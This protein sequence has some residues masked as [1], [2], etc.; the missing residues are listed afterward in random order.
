MKKAIKN[1]PEL[2]KFIGVAI[3]AAITVIAIGV[4]IAQLSLQNQ[5]ETYATTKA[6]PRTIAEQEESVHLSGNHE[7][8]Q[9]G[10]ETI[11]SNDRLVSNTQL[12]SNEMYLGH[13]R[14]A[15]ADPSSL[16]IIGSYGKDE[17]Q[18]FE[19]LNS[20]AAQALMKLIYAARH[21]KIWIVPVSAFRSFERQKILFDNQ[22]ERRGSIKEAAKISA[23]SGY[24]EH[25]TGLAVD[26]TDGRFPKQDITR[27][28]EHTDAFFWLKKHANE[29]GFEMSFP[30]KN[31]QGV[32]YEPWHWRFVGSA[33]AA[34]IFE[35]AKSFESSYR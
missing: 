19:Y 13:F 28:F 18:R 15:E 1:F 10:S 32:I 17:Y 12:E 6:S 29:F 8:S 26:L 2:L 16:T 30:A 7:P 25:H 11:P 14:Y 3:L 23:P 20:E 33:R 21:D 27:E 4:A 35:R 22:V 31:S 5:P 9:I 34:S 24:S